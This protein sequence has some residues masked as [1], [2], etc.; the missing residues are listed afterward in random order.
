MPLDWVVLLFTGGI[1]V[2]S[3]LLFGI[4]PAWL[5]TRSDVGAC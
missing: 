4:V 1:T 3:G 2:A 5:A